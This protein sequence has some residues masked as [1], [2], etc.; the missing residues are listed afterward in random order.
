M[1]SGSSSTPARCAS[2][3][4]DFSLVKISYLFRRPSG[5]LLMLGLLVGFGAGRFSGRNPGDGDL[6]GASGDP[7]G[8]R[9]GSA[10][11]E[12]DASGSRAESGRRGSKGETKEFGESV[13]SIF[14][15]TIKERRVAQ[16]EKFLERVDVSQFEAMVS[17]IRENDLLG[18]DTGEEWTRLWQAWGQ[19]DPAG[20]FEFMQQQD[21]SGWD[22]AALGEAKNRAL[23]SWAQTDPEQARRHVEES[24]E[25]AVGDRS[26]V[27][28]LVRGWSDVDP[29]GAVAWLAKTGL[30]MSG[31]Y[32]TVVEAISRRGGAEGL[33]AWFSKLIEEGASE[34]DKNGFAQ[35]IARLKQE[36]E[37][38]KAA[39]WVEQH[40][41][42]DW[43]PDSAIVEST[44]HAFAAR[45]PEGAMEWAAKTGIG[46]ATT[47]AMNSWCQRDLAAASLWMVRN[48][49]DPAYAASAPIVLHFMRREHPAAAKAWAESLPESPTRKQL[50][51][52][53][54]E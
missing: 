52:Q 32:G 20:A 10:T 28:G 30:G 46:H 7:S 29:D 39:A 48:A 34:Q 40:L 42:E 6:S 22:P 21:W 53:L 11:G 38:E 2:H 54:G 15:E 24:P 33:D 25:L 12:I 31:E 1:G 37:P 51:Q 44:A 3:P 27:F 19:R 18:N 5:L 23:I 14:R 45:D 17:L 43:L 49:A 8:S 13:R 41:D 36:Y 4:P 9:R 26:Q 47:A 16:F 50:L 35:A